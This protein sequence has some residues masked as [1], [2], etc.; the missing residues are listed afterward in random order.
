LQKAFLDAVNKQVRTALGV[1]LESQRVKNAIAVTVGSLIEQGQTAP[2]TAAFPEAVVN[3]F[4]LGFDAYPKSDGSGPRSP[5]TNQDL[6][7][8]IVDVIIANATRNF[9]SVQISVR[10]AYQEIASVASY[11]I[12][13]PNRYPLD[14]PLFPNQVDVARDRYVDGTPPSESLDLPPLTGVA[15]QDIEL[16]PPN[17]EAVGLLY[18]VMQMDRMRLFDVVDRLMELN[19]LGLLSLRFGPAAKA[20]DD[21]YWEAEDRMNPPARAMV[22]GRV[23]GMPGA[24]ISK[25]VQP[26]SG[27]E[28]A[29]I[30]FVAAI[31]E[32]DRQARVTNLIEPTRG[33][34]LQ[35]TDEMVRKAGR[36][37]ASNASL[38]GWSGTQ[39]QARR[40]RNMVVDALKILSLPE[41][42]NMYAAA[43]PYQVIE[44]VC[45]EE[46]KQVPNIVKLRTMAEAG[47]ELLRLVAKNFTAWGAS[48]T[49]PLFST[50]TP[51]APADGDI[52]LEDRLSFILQANSWVAVVGLDDGQLDRNSQPADVPYMPSVPQVGG[53]VA[54]MAPST[55]GA[56]SGDALNRLKQMMAS[57]AMPTQEQLQSLLSTVH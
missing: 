13:N 23:C 17:I 7:D 45:S 42:L 9:G 44:R 57:G 37:L 49:R 2:N 47:K 22:F 56:S 19:Q 54:T 38:Y 8:T 30:R 14:N 26:N 50:T 40:L 27:F 24:Q 29:L 48:P 52:T 5:T 55:N 20:L 21:W 15:G 3:A 6:Y 4:R 36:D 16:E 32:S 51:P 18:L 46:F 1:D 12:N 41:V 25:E 34:S 43:S 35:L 11:L 53:G 10:I 28:P 39:L 31:V 33:R